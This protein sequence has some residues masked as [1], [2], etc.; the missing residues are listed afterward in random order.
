MPG[1]QRAGHPAP[2]APHTTVARR[3]RSLL[4]RPPTP[5][6]E[7]SAAVLEE[8]GE[9][10][11]SCYGGR[12]VVFNRRA[13]ELH[14]FPAGPISAAEWGSKHDLHLRPGERR[15][16][17]RDLPLARALRG[18]EIREVEIET[19][20]HKGDARVMSV[21]GGPVLD[22]RGE[23]AG[24]ALIVH[25]VSDRVG[26]QA[27]LQ[28]QTAAAA[29]LGEAVALVRATDGDI[30][31]TN[32][33]WERM[34]GYGPGE[35]INRP[36]ALVHAPSEQT[37]EERAHEIITALEREGIWSGEV[38]NVRE[39][40]RSFWCAATITAFEHADQGTVWVIVQSDTTRRKAVAD[41][42][43]EAEERFRTVFQEGPV[44]LALIGDDQRLIDVNR[45]FRELVGLRRDELVGRPLASI[46]H[47]DDLALDADLALKVR[48]GEIP[49]YR[50]EKRYVTKRGESVQVA[51]TFTVV[52]APDGRALYGITVAEEIDAR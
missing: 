24:A 46:T 4:R 50:V 36:I 12:T 5:P 2:G 7:F 26:S 29:H 19:H 34:F 17:A 35:L 41:T 43:R 45:A 38:H 32:D 30:V 28:L 6:A 1:T 8:L 40:G 9:P 18:E 27:M 11:L 33:A 13:R 14:G 49:S 20:L 42:L 37:P 47:A 25:D 44:G 10:V 15:A 23:L 22:G 3:L 31:Y 21:S 39:D 48:N 51:V 16:P 52:R